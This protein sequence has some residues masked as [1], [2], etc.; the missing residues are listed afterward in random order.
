M[1][2]SMYFQ[3]KQKKGRSLHCANYA[4]NLHLYSCK[5]QITLSKDQV[6][7]VKNILL[8]KTTKLDRNK[9]EEESYPGVS[10]S[11]KYGIVH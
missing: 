1:H 5:I 10:I 11:Y 7:F 4:K 2:L 9:V 6:F 3:N 8:R